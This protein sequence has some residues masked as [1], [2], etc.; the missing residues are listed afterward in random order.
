MVKKIMEKSIPF[1]TATIA[2]KDKTL[3]NNLP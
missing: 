1:V 3:Q 2:K